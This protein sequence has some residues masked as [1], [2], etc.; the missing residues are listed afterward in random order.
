MA[1]LMAGLLF[2]S[3]LAAQDKAQAHPLA[4]WFPKNIADLVQQGFYQPA[5]EKLAEVGRSGPN[6]LAR[7]NAKARL[8]LFYFH[9]L[10]RP[11]EPHAGLALLKQAIAEGEANLAW[12]VLGDVWAAGWME[13]QVDYLMAAFSWEAAARGKNGSESSLV[14]R[15]FMH[16]RLEA[17]IQDRG[18]PFFQLE[19]LL[20]AG[21]Q[22]DI[23]VR[24][25]EVVNEPVRGLYDKNSLANPVIRDAVAAYWLWSRL[26]EIWPP[27]ILHFLVPRYTALDPAMGMRLYS[28]A[29]LRASYDALRCR[30]DWALA[31]F[32]NN[33]PD[34][35]KPAARMIN[36]FEA[37]Q[38]AADA[39][40][41]AIA[42]DK[43]GKQGWTQNWMC[44]YATHVAARGERAWWGSLPAVDAPMM[45][46]KASWPKIRQDIIDS[47]RN[48]LKAGS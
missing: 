9:G 28:L 5:F 6:P 7:A 36:A 42:R 4:S 26:D 20:K 3:P 17:I 37:R 45:R 29:V 18:Q 38:A 23:M 33:L 35:A 32:G 15:D 16:D 14:K 1:V 22:A 46:D 43:A 11:V 24:L 12:E 47:M 31:V 19:Q 27:A 8:S 25:E 34:A 39:L 40:E 30:E 13:G 21:R 48:A 41:W 10:G 2:A 44:L